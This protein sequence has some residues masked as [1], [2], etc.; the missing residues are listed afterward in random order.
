MDHIHVLGVTLHHVLRMEGI[1]EDS[2]EV[3]IDM[4]NEQHVCNNEGDKMN[5]LMVLLILL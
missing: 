1:N 5:Y 3:R 4:K 2:D